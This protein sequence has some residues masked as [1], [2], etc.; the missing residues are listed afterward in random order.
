MVNR[1]KAVITSTP[2]ALVFSNQMGSRT[3][4]PYRGRVECRDGRRYCTRDS[5][6]AYRTD[7][8]ETCPGYRAGK[9][10]PGIGKLEKPPAQPRLSIQKSSRSAPKPTAVIAL[11]PVPRFGHARAASQIFCRLG[12]HRR[13]VTDVHR[14]PST[15]SVP[16]PFMPNQA[17]SGQN[18]GRFRTDE[19]TARRLVVTHLG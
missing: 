19:M 16:S 12:G 17:F 7:T 3:A 6:G 1:S 4:W 10:R 2:S 9:K 18:R 11:R 14:C 13:V 15:T 5:R 8:K